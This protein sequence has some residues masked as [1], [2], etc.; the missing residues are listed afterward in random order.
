MAYAEQKNEIRQIR[1]LILKKR[2][3][4]TVRNSRFICSTW[5]I[6][7]CQESDVRHLSRNTQLRLMFRAGKLFQQQSND[8]VV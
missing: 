2:Y 6:S 3:Y 4:F 5:F 7:R 1:Y 8:T